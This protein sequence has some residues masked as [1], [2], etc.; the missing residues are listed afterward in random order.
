MQSRP[1]G[2][3]GGCAKIWTE[4]EKE[5]RGNTG[6]QKHN[7]EGLNQCIYHKIVTGIWTEELDY[8]QKCV[9]VCVCSGWP[10][11]WWTAVHRRL[12]LLT[13]PPSPRTGQSV[14][15]ATQTHRAHLSQHTAHLSC[16]I[17]S[18][19]HGGRVIEVIVSKWPQC[20]GHKLLSFMG[21]VY[22]VLVALIELENNEKRTPSADMS[23]LENIFHVD[24]E[25]FSLNLKYSRVSRHL[26]RFLLR[27][28][29]RTRG[30]DG[31]QLEFSIFSTSTLSVVPLFSSTDAS[32]VEAAVSG[33]SSGFSE[34]STT[35]A[36]R[37]VLQPM[38]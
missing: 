29:F 1:Q 2:R 34:G 10:R 16:Q 30:E 22:R 27:A 21:E 12:L 24:C 11:G 35:V 6:T 19:R 31:T 8:L 25:S 13:G 37:L 38:I 7:T 23:K 28:E 4:P 3:G 17:A 5:Y 9:C 14:H 20:D 36:S 26:S 18:E 33:L 15:T 32:L